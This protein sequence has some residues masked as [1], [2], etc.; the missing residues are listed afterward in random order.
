M[1]FDVDPHPVTQFDTDPDPA[2]KMMQIRMHNTDASFSQPFFF[3]N[4]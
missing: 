2:F 1:N 4:R 3:E